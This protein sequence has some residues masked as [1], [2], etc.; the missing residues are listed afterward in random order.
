M[1][2]PPPTTDNLLNIS[3]LNAQSQSGRLKVANLTKGVKADR[4]QFVAEL[5]P[6][7]ETDAADH[8]WSATS[9]VVNDGRAYVTWHSNHQA[10]T[11]ADKWGGAI[12]VIDIPAD[13]SNAPWE[14][15]LTAQNNSI[16][17]NQG[18]IANGR[19]YLAG[20]GSTTG[21]TVGSIALPITETS[22][23]RYINLPGSSANG[24]ELIGS[25]LIAATGYDGGAYSFDANFDTAESIGKV[26]VNN[27]ATPNVTFDSWL[28]ESVNNN[29]YGGK[30]VTGG[31]V[32]RTDDNVGAIVPVNNPSQP[33]AL[34]VPL[35]STEKFAEAYDPEAGEWYPLDGDKAAHYG[36]HT[37]A[38]DGDF[39][40]VGAGQNGLHVYNVST[41][42]SVWSNNNSTTAVVSQG[43]YI[44]AAT[45]IG[46]RVYK[47][48]ADGTLALYAYDVDEYNADGTANSSTAASNGHSANFVAVGGGYIFVAYGQTGV[49]IYRLDENAPEQPETL[50]TTLEVPFLDN[51]K[52]TK[53]IKPDENGEFTVPEG[54]TE[55]I[56]EGKEFAGWSTTENGTEPEYQPNET[57]EIPAGETTTLYP[58]WKDKAVEYTYTITFDLE[59]TEGNEVTGTAPTVAP[60]KTTD[61]SY[62]YTVPGQ[63]DIKKEGFNFKGWSILPSQQ[64]GA[65][66]ETYGPLDINKNN[67]QTYTLDKDHTSV[68]FYPVWEMKTG[69]GSTGGSTGDES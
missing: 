50:D 22:T 8:N 26:Q 47:K 21:A 55:N 43:D 7:A 31:Y 14:L 39:A 56:P 11:Q 62:V 20:T 52:D 28:G 63:G 42:A 17:L 9:V 30:Y 2:I 25:N 46:L 19:L 45:G 44:Y 40:Y 36:K 29:S 27:I 16:K 51:Y 59:S 33:I 67:K 15:Q 23:L 13:G 53:Q 12:D 34:D 54:P 3:V 38:I 64:Q 1:K 61:E 66:T 49:R 69:G 41:G 32:L 68:T 5:G 35:T 57:V 4:L 18:Y 65:G 58:V 6:V 37:M 10:A 24:V 60:I 48:N